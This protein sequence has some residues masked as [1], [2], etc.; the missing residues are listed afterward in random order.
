MKG[1]LVTNIYLLLENSSYM[2]LIT[3]SIFFC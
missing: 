2:F 3:E 1:I